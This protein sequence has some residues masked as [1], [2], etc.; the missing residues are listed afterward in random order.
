[1]AIL[2]WSSVPLPRPPQRRRLQARGCSHAHSGRTVSARAFSLV[3]LADLPGCPAATSPSQIS[4]RHIGRTD[5]LK[6]HPFGQKIE[7]MLVLW[8]TRH[9]RPIG[10]DT[11]K[12]RLA[13]C[14]TPSVGQGYGLF[15]QP[16]LMPK[17]VPTDRVPPPSVPV[18]LHPD[19]ARSRPRPA[20]TGW[21][22]TAAQLWDPVAMAIRPEW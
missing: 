2:P 11:Q 22:G 20:P 16:L 9:K 7:Q 19:A 12:G 15:S 3:D 13:G 8:P 4:G 6:N 5:W 17:S 1:M 21:A 18:R 14:K 10:S